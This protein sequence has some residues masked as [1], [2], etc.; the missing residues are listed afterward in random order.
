MID[1]PDLE[2]RDEDR[3]AAEAIART[4]GNL[5]TSIVKSQINVRQELLKLIE[6][7]LETPICEELTNANPSAP[8]TVILE[9]QAWLLAQVAY[10]FNKIPEQNFVAFANLF[11]IEP[12]AETKAE[13]ILRFQ[14]SVPRGNV[15]TIPIGSE[16]TNPDGTITFETTET[17]TAG[18][19]TQ[20]VNVSANCTETGPVLLPPNSLTEMIDTIAFV[21][22]V[23]NQN[24]I[25][26]GS[27][28]ESLDSTLL[29]VK[30]Y[31]RRGERL[32]STQD[33]E[34]AILTEAL[35]GN[36]IVRAFP[37]TVEG[38][39]DQT[40]LGYTTVVA[41]TKNG[42][43]L[44]SIALQAIADVLKQAVGNQF[45]S[46]VNPFFVE[47]DIEV[48]VRLKNNLLSGATLSAI[49]TNLRA[50]YSPSREQF[51]RAIYRSEIIAIIEAT[52]GVDRI[53]VPNREQIL[54]AP[55][56]DRSLQNHEL[57]KLINV[58]INVV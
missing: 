51:G 17:V 10:R 53:V 38:N 26:S 35:N 28:A 31:Q 41:M 12:Q 24:G 18:F 58:T 34:D 19:G 9:A 56:A 21:N 16:V 48:N 50:F 54:I 33:L 52:A 42:D 30:N 3:L 43:N 11:G 37:F 5:T 14:V 40:K 27:F 7:G 13:T 15:A 23:T 39:F 49:K 2:I 6:N 1:Y 44:D 25:D 4:T 55:G 36:G 32:V 22:S 20:F 8:H 29:R 47:F 45:I 46:I 57:P